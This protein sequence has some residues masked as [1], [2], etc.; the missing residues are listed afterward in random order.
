VPG[1]ASPD[2]DT[3]FPGHTQATSRL[4]GHTAALPITGQVHFLDD[5]RLLSTLGQLGDSMPDGL[6]VLGSFH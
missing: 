1:F 2:T 6:R 3:T 5:T 4:T